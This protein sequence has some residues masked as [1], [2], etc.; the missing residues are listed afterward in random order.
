MS[1]N[2]QTAWHA[3]RRLG[4]RGALSNARCWIQLGEGTASHIVFYMI[5]HHTAVRSPR[6]RCSFA[7]QTADIDLNTAR[8]VQ[9]PPI[10]PLMPSV[11]LAGALLTLANSHDPWD[12]PAWRTRTKFIV[13]PLAGEAAFEN[14]PPGWTADTLNNVR[15][16]AEA[17]WSHTR[18][19]VFI[20]ALKDNDAAGRDA[21]NKF[22]VDSWAR[23]WDLNKA[24]DDC[25]AQCFCDSWT[26]LKK[27]NLKTVSACSLSSLLLY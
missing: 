1:W 24:I 3:P 15:A 17:Y 6:R 14:P 16:F 22:V 5:T 25:L 12:W 19:E 4:R 13:S 21:W 27:F 20:K 23:K 7:R 8:Y 2:L 11:T 18:P 10:S 9:N 26:I